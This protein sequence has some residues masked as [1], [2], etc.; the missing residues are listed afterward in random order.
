MWRTELCQVVFHQFRELRSGAQTRT[1]FWVLR[2]FEIFLQMDKRARSLNQSFEKIII[3]AVAIEPNLL[4][5]IVRFVVTLV[6]PATKKR[7]IKGVVRYVARKIA[8]VA[9]EPAHNLRNLLAFAHG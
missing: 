5:D 6:V 1:V 7:A 2:V 8:I 9:F 4:Q 3:V